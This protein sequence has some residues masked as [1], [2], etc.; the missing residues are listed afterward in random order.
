MTGKLYRAPIP[1]F[2]GERFLLCQEDGLIRAIFLPGHLPENWTPG[3]HPVLDVCA[4]ALDAFFLGRDFDQPL[5]L[6]PEGTDFQRRVWAEV[7][8]IPRGERRTYGQ[9][10]RALGT[11]GAA[12]AVGQA[13]RRNPIPLLI[14]C[15]RVEGVSGLTGYAG[16]LALK[17]ALLRLEGEGQSGEK[18][19]IT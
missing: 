17:E 19:E 13:C 6:A 12:R 8:R 11:P 14:P 15:H 3:N 9:I 5:P 1:G 7:S 4:R 2:G 10:A 16:G 18:L